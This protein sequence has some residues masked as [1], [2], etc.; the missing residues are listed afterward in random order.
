MSLRRRVSGTN[1]HESFSD[2]AL[3]MLA[4][5]IFL[6]V[7]ILITNKISEK[8]QVPRLKEEIQE[9]RAKLAAM[10]AANE[11]LSD[12]VEQMFIMTSDA[13][14]VERVLETTTFGRKDFDLF[15]KGLKN[16]PGD[17][18]HMVVDGTGSMHG[19][20]SF[21]I[22]VLRL[23]VVRSGKEL[24]AISWFAD[25]DVGTYTGTMGEMLDRLIEGA[26]FAGSSEQIGKAF[27]KITAEHPAPSAYLL[28]GDEPSR[29]QIHYSSI[30]APVFTLPI[31]RADPDT[32]REFQTL[33]DKTG[34]QLLQIDFK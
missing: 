5:F 24:Q 20:T 10:E 18:L 7:T 11:S 1:I 33:A 16:I 3:L 4:T 31:G 19:V 32:Q 30:P 17:T 6:L 13:S 23:I 34:G 12:S 27:R 25:K 21:L 8:N 9:L 29:D 28:I 14:N 26:P 2:V 15:I 22:P